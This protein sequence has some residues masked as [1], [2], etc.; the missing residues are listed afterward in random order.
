ML[1]AVVRVALGIYYGP[2]RRLQ[3][4]QMPP[5]NQMNPIEEIPQ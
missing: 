4:N 5:A 3:L 2:K 1:G